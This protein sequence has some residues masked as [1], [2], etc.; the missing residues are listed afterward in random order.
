PADAKPGVDKMFYAGRIGMWFNNCGEANILAPVPN[1]DWDVSPLPLP[2]GQT[3]A[4]TRAP[5][6]GYAIAAETKQIDAVWK[7]VDFFGSPESALLTEGVPS[8][9]AVGDAGTY[10]IAKQPGVNWKNYSDGLANSRD[11][12]V[13][14]E[15]QDMDSAWGKEFS[16]FWDNKRT[17]SQLATILA[18]IT[19]GLL[20]K[21]VRS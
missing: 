2:P 19:T 13:T 10:L 11:E 8:R 4:T 12:P 7:A 9:K 14:T 20:Q 1:V 15:F 17:P 5:A 3:V 18:P 16:P 21:A 6:D